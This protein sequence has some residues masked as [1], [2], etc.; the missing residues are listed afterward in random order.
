P[1]GVARFIEKIKREHA[2]EYL[3]F[4]MDAGRSQRMVLF[5]QY[6][7]TREKMPDEMRASIPFVVEVVEAMGIP[8]IRLEGYEADDVIGTLARKASEAGIDTVI[9][10]GD[11]DFH[12]LVRPG[13]SLLNPGRGGPGGMDAEWVDTTNA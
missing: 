1:W 7:A 8:V 10:S 4:V 6:K 5:P 12:Q 11:K 2:P 9:V 3:G 13:V